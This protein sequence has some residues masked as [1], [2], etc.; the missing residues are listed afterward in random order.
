MRSCRAQ[1]PLPSY[2]SLDHLMRSFTVEHLVNEGADA[3]EAHIHQMLQSRDADLDG[4]PD[5]SRQPDLNIRFGRGHSDAFSSSA[6]GGQIG[7]RDRHQRLPALSID[8]FAALPR[9][10]AGMRVLD[11]GVMTYGTSLLSHAMGANVIVLKE[12]RK[13]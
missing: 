2:P 5:A 3:W 11:I 9:S 6:L 12:V 4:C 7:H 10:L 1:P 8:E 13:H